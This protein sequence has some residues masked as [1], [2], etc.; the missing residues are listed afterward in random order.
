MRRFALRLPACLA[1]MLIVLFAL[2]PAAYALPAFDDK[3]APADAV[4]L[5]DTTSGMVLYDNGNVGKRIYPASTTKIMTALLVLE[6]AD[7]SKTVT[8]GEEVV[9]SSDSSKVGL[10]PGEQITVKDLLYGMM[11][12]SG[13]DAANALAVHVGGSKESFVDMMNEKAQEL[14]MKD[15]HF[16]NA[17]GLHDEKHYTTAA[18]MRKLLLYALKNPNFIDIVSRKEY[19][20]PK[21]NKRSK[22][23]VL[24]TTNKLISLKESDKG[25]NYE[26]AVGGKT[27]FTTP[28]GK[29][30]GC[31][32][33]LA[34]KDGMKLAALIFGDHS[35]KARKRWGIAKKLCEFGFSNFETADIKSVIQ[36]I[37][38]AEQIKNASEQDEEEG[39]M[40]FAPAI[41]ESVYYTGEK[42]FMDVISHSRESISVVPAFTRELAA[43]IQ[44]GD[45]YGT[46]TY[47][48]N[49]QILYSCDLVATR[50][51]DAVDGETPSASG[52][53]SSPL[54]TQKKVELF[55]PEQASPWWWMLLPAALILFIV[56][57]VVTLKKKS[58]SR[59]KN[60]RKVYHYRIR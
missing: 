12:A 42:G 3:D 39:L 25:Y 45:V 1:A 59:F 18:D 60:K 20:I 41:K 50:D 5:V 38:V 10:K 34:E 9:V 14:G 52:G 4:V 32:V 16:V 6:K 11:V 54:S 44:K 24:K 58:R 55:A 28:G 2:L 46:V 31:L 36:E 35:T 23:L 15:T 37:T 19:T 27:G 21:S 40:E 8:V 22:P 30:N 48:L 43:P 17:H 26:Y 7:L 51:M 53:Q 56:I 29:Y 49:D 47:K 57:R 33:A 13:N